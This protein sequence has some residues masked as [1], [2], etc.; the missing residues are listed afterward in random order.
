M[1]NVTNAIDTML[2]VHKVSNASVN[3]ALVTP[4]LQE[5]LSD[6]DEGQALNIIEHSV[7]TFGA[8]ATQELEERIERLQEEFLAHVRQRL[9]EKNIRMDEKLVVSL[10]HDN[11]LVLQC[12]EQEE[13]LLA[14]LGE[15]EILHERLQQLRSAAF[16]AQA[17]QYFTASHAEFP[18]VSTSEYHVCFKGKLSHFYL[19]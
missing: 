11:M 4:I 10:S 6:T 9:F 12:Q 18:E 2:H 16:L 14:A 3:D 15:D 13:A 8:E 19:K 17:L 1:K 5:P 7:K